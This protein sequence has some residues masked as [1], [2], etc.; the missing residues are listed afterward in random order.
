[1]YALWWF[2]NTELWIYRFDRGIACA[3]WPWRTAQSC[4]LP[5]TKTCFVQ[6]FPRNGDVLAQIASHSC[7]TLVR[8][9]MHFVWEQA[10]ARTK[11]RSWTSARLTAW[12][13][14]KSATFVSLAPRPLLSSLAT[15]DRRTRKV[16]SFCPYVELQLSGQS[17][18]NVIT[19]TRTFSV[20]EMAGSTK[21]LNELENGSQ[22]DLPGFFSKSCL[23]YSVSFIEVVTGNMFQ[24]Y[25][26]QELLKWIAQIGQL[27]IDANRFKPQEEMKLLGF[28]S[29]NTQ[30]NFFGIRVKAYLEKLAG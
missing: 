13:G 27:N 29:K 16:N 20:E 6:C 12:K 26:C 2:W 17:P 19:P 11:A 22:T 1:M 7:G 28:S 14:M 25:D 10:G 5:V 8:S 30:V 18:W 24:P 3:H 23:K 21:R 4:W 15:G 9:S